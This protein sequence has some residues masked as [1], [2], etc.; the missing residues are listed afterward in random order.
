MTFSLRMKQKD[1]TGVLEWE[2]TVKS[3]HDPTEVITHMI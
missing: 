2:T 1:N 3:C